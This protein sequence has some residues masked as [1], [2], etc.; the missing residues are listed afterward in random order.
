MPPPTPGFNVALVVVLVFV[1]IA[2][3]TDIWKYQVHNLLTIPLMATGVIFQGCIGWY[4]GG[5]SGAGVQVGLS[6]EGMAFGFA[7]LLIPYLM[8]GMGAG[9]VKLLM[10]I[11]SWLTFQPTLYVFIGGA[12]AAGTCAIVLMLWHRSISETWWKV[13]ILLYRFSK[14]DLPL[15]GLRRAG[16]QL[17]SD[18]HLEEHLNE[19]RRRSLIP[20]GAMLF[21]GTIGV[22]V[23]LHT[24]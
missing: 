14:E 20:F 15:R 4:E 11:G 18:D 13:R 6:L 5:W 16:L 23:W 17:A 19:S 7:V 10:A 21:V 9:D 2:A 12:L 24:L 22:A 8:G 1:G 3:V